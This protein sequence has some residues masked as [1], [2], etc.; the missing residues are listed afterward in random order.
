LFKDKAVNLKDI[1]TVI[2]I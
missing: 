2:I 1:K